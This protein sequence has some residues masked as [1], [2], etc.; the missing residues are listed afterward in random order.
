VAEDLEQE[1]LLR[2]GRNLPHLRSGTEIAVRALVSR[3]LRSVMVDEV[4]RRKSRPANVSPD[5][6]DLPGPPVGQAPAEVQED[7]ARV[8]GLFGILSEDQRRVLRMHFQEGLALRQIAD[9]LGVPRGTV[10]AWYSRALT[11][12]R[13]RLS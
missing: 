4:R 7:L 12:L 6:E 5:V 11:L 3:V 1:A 2:L 8:R 13:E 10:A 9:V